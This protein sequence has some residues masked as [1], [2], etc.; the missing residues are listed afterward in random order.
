MTLFGHRVATDI[1][2]YRMRSYWSGVGL[3]RGDLG[4]DTHNGQMMGR[5]QGGDGHITRKAETGS[6]ASIS[7]GMPSTAGKRQKPEA[8]RRAS[9]EQVSGGARPCRHFSFRLPASG[10]ETVDCCCLKPPNGW[11]FV[12]QFE[13]TGARYYVYPAL[14]P[15]LFKKTAC[16]PDS[17]LSCVPSVANS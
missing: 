5:P 4:P 14:R 6:D 15:V 10:T 1:I 17:P 2:S 8:A 12:T 3:R 9:P 16:F 13:P 11:T 7:H